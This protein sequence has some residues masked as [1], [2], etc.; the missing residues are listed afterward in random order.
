MYW[1][2]ITSEGQ[3]ELVEVS[4]KMIADSYVRNILQNYVMPYA[5]FIRFEIFVLMHDNLHKSR[6]VS[7]I[8]VKLTFNYILHI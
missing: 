4:H 2:D 8:F 3:K 5:G 7:I 1:S 6:S